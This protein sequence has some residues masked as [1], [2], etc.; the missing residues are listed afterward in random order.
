MSDRYRARAGGTTVVRPVGTP[1]LDAGEQAAA[2]RESLLDQLVAKVVVER[3][4]A[5]VGEPGSGGAE[6]R[7]VLPGGAERLAVAHQLAGHVA[8]GVVG[9]PTLELVDGHR[10]G[11]VEHVDLLELRGGAELRRHHVEGDVAVR[12]DPGIALADA[13]RLDDDQVVGGPTG[14]DHVR[15]MLGDLGAS[16]ARGQ[17][18]EVHA[19]E[20][21]RVHPDPVAEQRA[22]AL[23]PGRIDGD[24]R[25][26]QLALLVGAEPA[27]Q[28]IG[29]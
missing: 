29:E 3:G 16:A 10:V 28:L 25:D 24:D 4:D 5:V 14:S 23:A 15:E 11:V 9:A 20:V 2:R 7:H 8:P 27:Q 12:H 6:H 19:A 17:R 18:A 21:D 22:A 26:P 1:G 13:G